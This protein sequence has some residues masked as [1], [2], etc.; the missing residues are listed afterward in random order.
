[1]SARRL[2]QAVLLFLATALVGCSDGKPPHYTYPEMRTQLDG[3]VWPDYGTLPDFKPW[4]RDGQAPQPDAPRGDGPRDGGAADGIPTCPGPAAAKCTSVCASDELCTE[5]KG[6]MCTKQ[7]VL[8]GAATDKVVLKVVALAFLTC[9]NKAPSADTL[10]S[11]FN[12]CEMTGN[13]TQTAI[14]D[15][16]CNKAQVGDFPS[17][18]EYDG[19]R[20]IFRC[21]FWSVDFYRPEWKVSTVIAGKRGIVCLAY[22]VVSWNYDRINVN[23]CQFFPPT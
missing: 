4:Y 3:I 2:S 16:V 8:K 7:V 18:K 5:A 11:T 6:G 13:L 20:G 15:W 14:D 22:D 17:S 23:D 1:M 10:C 12:T 19:V 9:W 21:N